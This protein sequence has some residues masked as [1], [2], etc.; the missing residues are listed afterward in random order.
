MTQAS[1][2]TSLNC[3]EIA[4]SETATMVWSRAPRKIA[5]I[6]AVST[7]R[8]VVGGRAAVT[9]IPYMAAGLLRG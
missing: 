4:G 3:A 7:L 2:P 6:R 1:R 5:S 8:R 9:G